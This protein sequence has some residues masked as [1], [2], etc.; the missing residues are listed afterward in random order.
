MDP[1]ERE[2]NSGLRGRY[3]IWATLLNV[4]QIKSLVVAHFWATS[5][6]FVG[7][8]SLDSAVQ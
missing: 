4:N 1:T 6:D 5:I 8:V 7:M 3:N 2:G